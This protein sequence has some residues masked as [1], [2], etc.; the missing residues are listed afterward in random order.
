MTENREREL[1]R[2]GDEPKTNPRRVAMAGI[3]AALGLSMATL[4]ASGARGAEPE[5]DNPSTGAAPCIVLNR[6]EVEPYRNNDSTVFRAD[7]TIE[8]ICGRTMEVRFCFLY[9][10]A[11]DGKDRSCFSGPVRPWDTAEVV[12]PTAPARI[13]RSDY[14][15]R[16][17][18]E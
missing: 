8:N 3:G 4:G 12:D 18:P 15:W 17:L 11:V 7:A 6:Y 1:K 2:V 10:Q 13:T 5:Y 16:Y 14:Q 9:S